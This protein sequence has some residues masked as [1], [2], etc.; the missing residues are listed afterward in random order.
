MSATCETLGILRKRD[1]IKNGGFSHRVKNR[2]RQKQKSYIS[3]ERKF[4]TDQHL[5]KDY[6][7]KMY[8]FRD[9]AQS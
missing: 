4:D 5:I 3:M 6:G 1:K 8:R 7:L 2:Y 9:N